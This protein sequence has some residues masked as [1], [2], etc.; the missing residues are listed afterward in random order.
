MSDSNPRRL[1]ATFIRTH[2][3][4][5]PSPAKSA[6]RRRMLGWR[7][8]ELADAAG[9]SVT[10]LTWLEQGREVQASV[11]TL[12]R[13]AQALNLSAA[14]R[15][16]LF[17]LAGKRDPNGTSETPTDIL[18]Q[19]LELP[20]LFNGPAYLIDRV[21]T[22]RAWNRQAAELFVDWLGADSGERNLLNYV[23]LNADAQHFIA[24]WPYRAQRLPAEFRA[25]YHRRPLDSDLQQLVD[26]LSAQSPAFAKYWRQ[27]TVLHR[28]GGERRFN[29]PQR[30]N[31]SYRQTTLVVAMQQDCKLVCLSPII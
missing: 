12:T 17:D 22:S 7:R 14:E 24:D 15:S 11:T 8:E 10:W 31:L 9:V 13:L 20:A 18:P 27:Q 16:S 26:R 3:E 1:L 30:G 28:E 19:L 29:H 21:W 5:L 2:R 23:F 6:G 25:D 4:H